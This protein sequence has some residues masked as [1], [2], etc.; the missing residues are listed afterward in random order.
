[1]IYD[2]ESFPGMTVPLKNKMVAV[3]FFSGKINI[4]GAKS[5]EEVD[6]GEKMI[7]DFISEVESRDN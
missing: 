2:Q 7:L 4:T 5:V 6:H 3:V 1:M